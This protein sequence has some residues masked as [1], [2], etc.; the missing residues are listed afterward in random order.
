M[1]WTENNYDKI[2]SRRSYTRTSSTG[3]CLC[4]PDAYRRCELERLLSIISSKVS[5]GHM[6]VLNW[7]TC[8]HS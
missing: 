7:E 3:P 5:V 1:R 6:H 8:I 2:F 4:C